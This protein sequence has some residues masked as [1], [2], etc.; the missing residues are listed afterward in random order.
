MRINGISPISEL[1]S[2]SVEENEFLTGAKK[3]IDNDHS[4]IH[5]G[6]YFT[7]AFL[8]N[9]NGMKNRRHYGFGNWNRHIHFAD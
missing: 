8:L 6:K 5:Q 2:I 4:Y 3:V 7:A 9:C 1:A